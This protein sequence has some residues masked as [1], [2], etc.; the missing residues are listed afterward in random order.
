MVYEI[1]ITFHLEAKSSKSINNTFNRIKKVL[2]KD[3]ELKIIDVQNYSF[4]VE[5]DYNHWEKCVYEIIKLSQEM[6]RKWVILGTLN[7]G[8][9][10]WTNDPKIIGVKNIEISCENIEKSMK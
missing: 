7:F 4:L 6:G 1:Y 5:K 10:L 9:T 8:F 2:E 3:L